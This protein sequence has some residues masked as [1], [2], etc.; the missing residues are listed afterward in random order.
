M[1]LFIS[2]ATLFLCM[3]AIAQKS[4]I[5]VTNFE[6]KKRVNLQK[7]SLNDLIQATTSCGGDV[8]ISFEDIKMSGGCAGVLERT[9]KLTDE[10]N[11]ELK[12][13]QYIS[14][15]DENPPVFIDPPADIQLS[16]KTELGTPLSLMAEDDSNESIVIDVADDYDTTDPEFVKVL[17]TWTATDNCGNQ[18]NYTQTISIPTSRR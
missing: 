12:K 3:P 1:K 15:I 9:Y 17:R 14:L 2:L 5:K 11:N 18:S 16:D 13:V 7:T 8:Q 4:S 6:V 10:C